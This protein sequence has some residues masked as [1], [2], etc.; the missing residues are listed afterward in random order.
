[1]PFPSFQNIDPTGRMPFK[2][3][4][5]ILAIVVSVQSL[6]RKITFSKVCLFGNNVGQIYVLK[7]DSLGLGLD[8]DFRGLPIAVKSPY[9]VVFGHNYVYGT[10]VSGFDPVK[11][12]TLF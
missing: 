4:L 12:K 8:C 5:S 6:D 1:M 7:I 3:N 11:F 9:R 10:R 2:S